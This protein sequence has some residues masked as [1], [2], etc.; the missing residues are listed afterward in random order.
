MTT[1]QILELKGKQ[2]NILRVKERKK[3]SR[4]VYRESSKR[5]IHA[6]KVQGI[7]IPQERRTPHN[8]TQAYRHLNKVAEF[9]GEH[10]GNHT[11]RKTCGYWFYKKP[12]RILPCCKGFYIIPILP[13]PYAIL[14]L[15]NDTN[16]VLK[17]FSAFQ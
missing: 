5:S 10:V 9:V 6:Q 17:T 2:N 14:V 12:R 1:Q 3:N 16:N 13:S 8:T 11:L 7:P 4:H 15:S